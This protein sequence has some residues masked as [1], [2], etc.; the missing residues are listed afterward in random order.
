MWLLL[1]S[2]LILLFVQFYPTA[3]TIYISLNRLRAGQMIWVGTA[4][5][6]RLFRDANFYE[7]LQKSFTF[8]AA[9]VIATVVLGLLVAVLLNQRSRFNPFYMVMLF[10]PWV[11][12]DVVAGTVWRWLFQQDYGLIQNLISPLTGGTSLY[13]RPQ[14]AM[15][16][17]I[18][19][20]IWRSL[21]FTSLLFLG[22]LQHVSQEV[23]ESAALDGASRFTSFFRVTLPIIRPTV[24]VAIILATIGGLNSVGVILTLTGNIPATETASVYLYE[25]GWR[26]G[27]FGLGA[28]ISIIMFLI[29]LILTLVYLRFQRE[30]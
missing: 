24:M 9:T 5:F 11:I 2:L 8:V 20:T 1:P 14:G 12:S 17:V 23:L 7:S 30:E 15:L 13:A 6:E 25:Q 22:A 16:I 4:N 10:V 28:A 19:A 3:Y 18:L 29:N 26:F 21:P 27:D